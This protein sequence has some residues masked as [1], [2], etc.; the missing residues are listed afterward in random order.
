L[1]IDGDGLSPLLLRKVVYA[2]SNNPSFGRAAHDLRVLAEVTVAVK[3]V[4]RW[5]KRI[6]QER[7]EERDAATAAWL[8]RP[9]MQ[10]EKPPADVALASLAVVEMDGGRLQI[11][12]P[13]AEKGEGSSAAEQGIAAGVASPTAAE[14]SPTAAEPS[15]TAAEPSPTAAEPSPTAAEPSPTAAR[16][17]TKRATTGKH[18]RED[19]VGC[20]LTMSSDVSLV[21]PCPQ[22]PAVFVDPLQSLKLA[23]QIGHAA[24]PAG[25]PFA[26]AQAES[27]QTSAEDNA[28]RPGR[29]KIVS[30]RVLASCKDVDAFGPMLAATACTLGLFAAERRA[31]VAD[32]SSENGSVFKR[33]FSRWTPVLDFLHCLT[34]VYKAA[35]ADRSYTAGWPVYQRWIGWV[36][37][38]EVARVIEELSLRAAELGEATASDGEGSARKVVAETLTYLRN[39]RDKMRYDEYRRQGLPLMSSHVES[40]IKQINYRVKGTEKFWSEAGAEALLE[41]R[42][43]YVSDEDELEDFWQRRQATA[44]GQRRYRRSA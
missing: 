32:G 22:I 7:H 35:M 5:T 11:R 44:T 24:V 26:K 18:W 25:A 3:Q 27:E 40:T 41:L 19:K 17:A 15:P 9:L 8:E 14:P 20:L 28:P 13:S 42:A 1:G 16:D 34:Y 39:H 10:R 12:S 6:G 37:G 38:G 2:G 4:E 36:W 43:D 21:D 29:P 33:Y 30:R 23:Q 31:F